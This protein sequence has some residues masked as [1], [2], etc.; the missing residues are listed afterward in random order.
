MNFISNKNIPNS[1]GNL[2]G[3]Q[4]F[5]NTSALFKWDEYNYAWMSDRRYVDFSPGDSVINCTYPR[6]WDDDGWQYKINQTTCR[7]S[8]FDLYGD[9]SNTGTLP[10]YQNQLSKYGSVQDRLRDWRSD[11]LD[12]IKHFSC[13]QIAMLDI[14]GFRMDKAVQ[15]TV[16]AMAEFADYQRQCARK[17]G[18]ENFYI[19]GEVVASEGQAAIYIGRGKQ[20]DMYLNNFTEAA[21]VSNKTLTDKYIRKY[22][23]SALDGSSFQYIIYGILSRFLGYVLLTKTSNGR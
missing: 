17:Y 11:V 13:I 9:S 10:A 4:G 7:D 2:L 1:M 15:T 20:P 23:L 21:L 19:M 14:D 12:K 8:E 22:G 16:D 5:M 3:F 6:V 18:K